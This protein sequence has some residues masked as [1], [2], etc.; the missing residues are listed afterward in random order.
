[1]LADRQRLFVG[2]IGK[3]NYY[4]VGVT[5][6]GNCMFHAWLRASTGNDS[7]SAQAASLLRHQVIQLLSQDYDFQT[8]LL[9]GI[10]DHQVYLT[11]VAADLGL[12]VWLQRQLAANNTSSVQ[13][14]PG[15]PLNTDSVQLAGLLAYELQRHTDTAPA[16]ILVALADRHNIDLYLIASGSNQLSP[17]HH[18]TTTGR[19]YSVVIYN[20]QNYH[21]E[22]LITESG[23]SLHPYNSPLI[24]SLFA[25]L[26]KARSADASSGSS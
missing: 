9:R 11:S 4:R 14:V 22:Y 18:R 5:G 13:L 26:T 7:S 20:L 25:L 15:T 6:D 17:Q 21:Y 24:R 19:R 8:S 2:N 12:Q 1:M 10:T 3:V 23:Q 16:D